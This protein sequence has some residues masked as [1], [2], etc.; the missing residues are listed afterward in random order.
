MRMI[1]RSLWGYW[2][3]DG[4]AMMTEEGLWDKWWSVALL[5]SCPSR[6]WDEKIRVANWWRNSLPF[7]GL[8]GSL[9]CSQR[10]R[11]W[12]VSWGTWIQST[13]LNPISLRFI[14]ILFPHLRLR[15]PSV[16]FTSVFRII[17][18][19][20]HRLQRYMPR[21]YH[22]PTF[23]S[24]YLLLVKDK[25]YEALYYSVFC[26]LLLFVLSLVSH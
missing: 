18:C 13:S 24:P 19:I 2:E 11:H 22:S 8:E 16:V 17:L 26:A 4:K 3:V 1:H 14:L 7:M 21:P 5:F 6:E 23:W 12:L 9:P 15:A 20:C 25:N 10:N